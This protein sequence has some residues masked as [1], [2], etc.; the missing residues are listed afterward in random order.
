MITFDV[1]NVKSV[2]PT[3]KSSEKATKAYF[4]QGLAKAGIVSGTVEAYKVNADSNAFG[5]IGASQNSFV[6]TALEA[7]SEHSPFAISPD[8][9][10]LLV[11]QA[12]SKHISLNPED[13]RKA[14]VDWDGKKTIQV[15]N[16]DFYKG[17][18]D[19]DWERE[20]GNFAT[21]IKSLIGK[22]ADLLNPTFSTTGPIEKAAIQV[23]MMAALA[24]YMEYQM[25]T[26]CGVPNVT[27]LGTP[28]DWSSITERVVAF[29]EFYPK[30]A[31][32]PMLEAVG[33]LENSA[34]G[35]PDMA[36]WK[37]F[38]KRSYGS[39]GTKVNGWIS[40]FFPYINDKPNKLMQGDLGESVLKNPWS[41]YEIGDFPSSIGTVP[42]TWDCRGATYKMA[43]A[44]GMMGSTTIDIG[45]NK[46]AYKTVIGWAVG[47]AK[48]K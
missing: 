12:V 20:F 26:M 10:W 34:H 36:F 30:W 21:K 37:N 19:N 33:H 22:K 2:S 14:L 17:S 18:P 44:S 13:C 43:L 15:V 7:F 8:D 38:F 25:M 45:E 11:I 5:I 24:P 46:K 16:D 32:G 3:I 39:G 47:E 27:L 4:N 48:P 41:G 40:A 28:D 9:V 35:K 29:G 42:M 6:W 23:Q 1:D 31:H